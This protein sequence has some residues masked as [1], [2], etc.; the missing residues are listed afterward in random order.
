MENT[1]KIGG[2]N[3]PVFKILE[4][5]GIRENL[6]YAYVKNGYLYCTDAHILLRQKLSIFG[7]DDEQA[8]TIEGKSFHRSTLETMWKFDQVIFTEDYIE[9]SK[10]KSHAKLS[11]GILSS[12]NMP[13]IEGLLNLK[14]KRQKQEINSIA[15]NVQLLKTLTEAM[16]FQESSINNQIVLEFFENINSGIIVKSTRFDYDEQIGMIMPILYNYE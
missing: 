5:D 3:T 6:S 1:K 14:L 12:E 7:I 2:F 16:L 4:K 13:D 10:D 8:K 9:C 15:F 11:Y